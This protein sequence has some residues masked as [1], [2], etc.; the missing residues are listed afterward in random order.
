MATS[1][2][3]TTEDRLPNAGQSWLSRLFDYKPFLI[4]CCL[5][6]AVG[7]LVGFLTY[8]LGL[9][10]WLAFTDTRIGRPGVFIGLENYYSLIQDRDFLTATW[11]TCLYTA[12]ATVGKFSLGLWLALLLNH[13]LP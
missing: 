11:W 9:G 2:S 5:L 3:V 12:V 6:P 10:V 1:T 13:H 7:L 8:P 4:V